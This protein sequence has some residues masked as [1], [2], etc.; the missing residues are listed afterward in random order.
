MKSAAITSVISDDNPMRCITA[1]VCAMP[2]DI[3]LAVRGVTD[4]A[5]E[6]IRKLVLDAAR[7]RGI[8]LPKGAIAVELDFDVPFEKTS[9][10][11]FASLAALLCS[12][13]AA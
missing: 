2:G 8:D 6:E 3:N 1:I 9:E 11:A 13:K 4:T 12:N 10:L 5:S 7:R